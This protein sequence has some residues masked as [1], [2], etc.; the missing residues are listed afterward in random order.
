MGDSLSTLEGIYTS[1]QANLDMTLSACP[2]QAHR[3]QVMT[4]YVTA[5]TNYWN[6]VNKAFHDDDPALQALVTQGKTAITAIKNIN[7][8]LGDITKVINTITQAVT[9][10]GEIAAKVITL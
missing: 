6:C 10:G 2:D 8:S 1:L 4:Q 9:I 7:D 5:R 3:D